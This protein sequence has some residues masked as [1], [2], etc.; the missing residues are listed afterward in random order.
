VTGDGLRS[1]GALAAAENRKRLDGPS[2]TAL[3]PLMLDRDAT[4]YLKAQG[5]TYR[6]VPAAGETV[7][8]KR[9]V[10]QNS[11]T[12]NHVIR[13]E[14]HPATVMACARLVARLGVR[15]AGVDIIAHDISKP[16]DRANGV[17]G[18]INTTPGLHHHDLVATPH[19]GLSPG[20]MLAEHLLTQD[21]AWP[22]RDN[23][24]NVQLRVAA[25]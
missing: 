20:A 4:L 5:L 14:V 25:G 18:E 21:C 19:E 10:N 3:S 11:R 24:S 7:I 1:I 2:V 13:N 22:A 8:V 17:I 9:A 6:S 12:E 23:G 15:L 16:L